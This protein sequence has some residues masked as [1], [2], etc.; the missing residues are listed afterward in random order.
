MSYM[1][2]NRRRARVRRHALSGWAEDMQFAAGTMDPNTLPLCANAQPGAYCRNYIGGSPVKKPG[3]APAATPA[4]SSGSSVATDFAKIFGTLFAS[5][6]T[7]PAPVYVPPPQSAISPTVMVIGG[8]AALGLL[9]VA[10]K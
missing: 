7:P 6:S 10:L 9:Y 8:V 4:A 3:T 5:A 1:N 2:N